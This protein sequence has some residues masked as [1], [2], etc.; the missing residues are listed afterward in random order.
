MAEKALKTLKFP[1]IET[2]Y[3]IEPPEKILQNGTAIPQNSDLNDYIVAGKYYA[4]DS[5]IAATITNTPIVG[6]GFGLLIIYNYI[7]RPT[8]FVFGNDRTIY[9]RYFNGTTW[10][11]WVRIL[12]NV[13][14]N[15]EYGTTL[16][17]SNLE[18]GRIFFLIPE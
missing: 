7:G 5:T 1:G 6:S 9:H 17:E 15:R 8:Q 3:T 12:D 11:S 10:S 16:P 2:I 18:N 14:T 13:L 4:G